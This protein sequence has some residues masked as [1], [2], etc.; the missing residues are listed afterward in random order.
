MSEKVHHFSVLFNIY[1]ISLLHPLDEP[2]KK[3]LKQ[4]DGLIDMMLMAI[5]FCG[6]W[7]E[8]F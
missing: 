7:D 2:H 5:V 1:T 8:I 4:F 3:G 6:S